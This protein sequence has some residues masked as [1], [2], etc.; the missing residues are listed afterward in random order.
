VRDLRDRSKSGGAKH[1]LSYAGREHLKT[2]PNG[3]L[4]DRENSNCRMRRGAIGF[5]LL[6][7]E[8][9]PAFNLNP[10]DAPGFSA[11]GSTCNWSQSAALDI[12]ANAVTGNT[13]P[14]R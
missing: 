14:S 5:P 7:K 9:T 3:L 12:S 1:R 10:A 4:Y 11:A 13:R 6:I 8:E 2:K